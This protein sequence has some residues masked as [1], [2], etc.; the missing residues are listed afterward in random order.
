[1]ICASPWSYERRFLVFHNASMGISF[2]KLSYRDQGRTKAEWLM[3]EIQRKKRN[4]N[5]HH[6][7]GVLFI[8][9]VNTDKT[10][11][12]SQLLK[13]ELGT[14]IT[15]LL[16]CKKK[17]ERKKEKT[18]LRQ[19]FAQYFLLNDLLPDIAASNVANKS[20][21]VK[22]FLFSFFLFSSFFFFSF[23]IEVKTNLSAWHYSMKRLQWQIEI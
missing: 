19:V 16:Y 14:H 3:T 4:L 23:F 10:V 5:Q 12:K 11:K 9:I 20:L 17:K 2:W 18:K 22:T 15:F 7:Y 6:C 1:M 21:Q 8:G 13:K